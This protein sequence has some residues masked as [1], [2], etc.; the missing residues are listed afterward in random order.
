MDNFDLKTDPVV[1]RK[2]ILWNILTVLVLIAAVALAYFFATIFINPN[3]PYNPFPPQPLP[4]VFLTPTSTPTRIPLPPTWTP[5]QTPM[6]SPTRTKAPTWTPLAELITPTIT[7]IPNPALEGATS[8]ASGA[9]MPATAD[10]TYVASTE[11]HPD[12]GCDWAGVG[13]KV[14]DANDQPISF[15]TVQLGGELGGN[16]VS[17]QAITGTALAYGNSGFEFKKLADAPIDSTQTLWVQLFDNKGNQLTQKI[18]FDTYANCEQNL[19]MI[20]FLVTP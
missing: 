3:V 16:P 8:D 20:D 10:I 9:V 19:V 7:M 1:K 18:Y 15:L 12:F 4:T 13:G 6:L 17:D 14:L 2:P 5:T 11:I